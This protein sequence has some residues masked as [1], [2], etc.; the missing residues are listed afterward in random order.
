MKKALSFFFIGLGFAALLFGYSR[1]LL[2]PFYFGV[3]LFLI[4]L[5]LSCY[6]WRKSLARRLWLLNAFLTALM[7]TAG[8]L[9][10]ETWSAFSAHRI[11]KP[12]AKAYGSKSYLYDPS[13]LKSGYEEWWKLYS[14]YWSLGL[15]SYSTKDP[16]GFYP[17]LVKPNSQGAFFDSNFKFNNFAL[18]GE[19]VTEQKPENVYRVIAIGESTTWGATIEAG[20]T[21]WPSKLESKINSIVATTGEPRVEF[22]VLNAGRAA[23]DLEHNLERIDSLLTLNPDMI[24]SYHGWNGFSRFFPDL[25]A[26]HYVRKLPTPRKR[27]SKLLEGLENSSRLALLN[28]LYA[29]EPPLTCDLS[30]VPTE[31]EI[32]R[33]KEGAYSQLYNKLIQKIP[34]NVKIVL[35]NFNMAVN[36]STPEEVA[37]FYM[38]G[39]PTTCIGAKANELH[40]ALLEDLA[41]NHPNVYVVNASA[42]IDGN[43]QDDIFVDIIHF[44]D[45]GRQ[46]LAANLSQK[47]LD[48]SRKEQSSNFD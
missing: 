40:S 31:R 3:A 19:N 8:L 30:S 13:G 47:V 18:R 44:T 6:L 42:G 48:I 7:F 2:L 46:S 28:L 11:E 16:D 10:Y 5:A 43:Y 37:R 4:G 33:A 45:F 39:F 41:L 27:P 9:A 22:E 36:R 23:Y 35:V 15:K 26:S 29:E 21:S 17:Y 34:P 32:L 25:Y 24:I 14:L 20:D 12:I 1:N 38:K